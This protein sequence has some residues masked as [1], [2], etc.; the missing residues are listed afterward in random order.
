[1]KSSSNQASS[2]F[3]LPLLPVAVVIL[4]YNFLFHWPMQKSLRSANSKQD[5]LSLK[6]VEPLD[7]VSNRVREKQLRNELAEIKEQTRSVKDEISETIQTSSSATAETVLV[8]QLS[9]LFERH[10]LSIQ[11]HQLA[12]QPKANEFS[13]LAEISE[14]YNISLGSNYTQTTSSE[15]LQ[16]SSR[17]GRGRR[18]QS[19]PTNQSLSRW[20]YSFTLK[21]KF[22]D[23]HHA[24]EEVVEQRQDV[25]PVSIELE[26]TDTSEDAPRSS[27]KWIVTFVR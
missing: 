3:L 5:R 25:I 22:S 13:R 9:E 12:D 1:M 10:S 24:I 27:R 26:G 7:L 20:A 15:S 19:A 17:R 6:E 4:A 18:N 23:I 2:G 14:R 21:G 16:T 8:N 11:N